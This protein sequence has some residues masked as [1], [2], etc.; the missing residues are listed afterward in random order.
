MA[1]TGGIKNPSL[2]YSIDVIGDRIVTT[3]GIYSKATG[4]VEPVPYDLR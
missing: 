2:P 4:K 1:S 3:A